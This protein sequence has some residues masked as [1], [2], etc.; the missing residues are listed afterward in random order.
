ML[1]ASDRTDVD[2]IDN[3]TSCLGS[4]AGQ[5]MGCSMSWRGTNFQRLRNKAEVREDKE[6]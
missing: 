6:E 2:K 5:E 1:S 4:I 3:E